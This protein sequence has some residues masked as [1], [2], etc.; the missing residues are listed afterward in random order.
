MTDSA[1]A[2]ERA[3][4]VELASGPVNVLTGGS[5]PSLLLLHHD[6]GPMGW[7]RFQEALS[8]HFTVFAM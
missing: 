8:E 4:Q 7:G 2:P 3:I 1:T 5:G 6:V